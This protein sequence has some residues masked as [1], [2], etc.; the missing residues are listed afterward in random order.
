[1]HTVDC[2]S[3]SYS[4]IL[5]I[6][7]DCSQ[8]AV[9]MP[10]ECHTQFSVTTLHVPSPDTKLMLGG[11]FAP[12]LEVSM[13][14]RISA[15]LARSQG[16]FSFRKLHEGRGNY[17]LCDN[18]AISSAAQVLWACHLRPLRPLCPLLEPLY[19]SDY[20]VP[21]DEEGI[22]PLKHSTEEPKY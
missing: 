2:R 7:I 1:M 17:I 21:V 19:C 22:S 8:D 12:D 11:A 20:V 5:C 14:L 18:L 6:G 3:A 4:S 16:V 9:F 10:H 13:Q 15:W